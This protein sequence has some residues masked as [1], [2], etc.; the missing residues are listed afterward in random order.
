MLM[1]TGFTPL[2]VNL[3]GMISKPNAGGG[4]KNCVAWKGHHGFFYGQEKR[5]AAAGGLSHM[6][7]GAAPL[8]TS[9]Q[10]FDHFLAPG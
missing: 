7:R 1:A 4:S 3:E 5:A 9:A 10:I 6:R 2:L 8:Q